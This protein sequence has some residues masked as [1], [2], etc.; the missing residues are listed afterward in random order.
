MLRRH[1]RNKMK[2]YQRFHM[3]R[4]RDKINCNGKSN[5]QVMQCNSLA[6]QAE[7]ETMKL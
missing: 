3:A 2:V 4:K 1:I 7:R 6:T 5:K